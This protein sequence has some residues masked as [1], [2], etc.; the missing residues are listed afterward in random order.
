MTTGASI[1]EVISICVMVATFVVIANRFVTSRIN[2]TI[3][4]QKIKRLKEEYDIKIAQIKLDYEKKI[5]ELQNQV[6]F[7]LHQLVEQ[8]VGQKAKKVRNKILLACGGIDR[9][10]STDKRVLRR[11][12]V[13]FLSIIDSDTTKISQEIRRALQDGEGYSG[14]HIAAHCDGHVIELSG[15]GITPEELEIALLSIDLVVLSS[16]KSHEIAD[17]LVSKDRA[18]I[19]FLEDIEDDVA[20]EAMYI[21]WRSYLAGE[22][23]KSAYE[24][25]RT[26]YPQIADRIGFRGGINL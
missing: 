23:P 8:N 10:C 9:F 22:T 19:T 12:N 7:L 13:N 6:T 4:D 14:V 26:M 2:I 5:E 25:V 20:E 3:C 24:S 17:K 15:R 21:F 16:C 18:I 11:A 1:L